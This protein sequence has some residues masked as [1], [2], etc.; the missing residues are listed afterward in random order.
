MLKSR[1]VVELCSVLKNSVLCEHVI[2]AVHPLVETSAAAL[3]D[4]AFRIFHPAKFVFGYCF[5]AHN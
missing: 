2:D 4:Q 1:T 3:K 5:N